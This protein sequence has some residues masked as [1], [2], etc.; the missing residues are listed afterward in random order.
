MAAPTPVPRRSTSD[1]RWPGWRSRRLRRTLIALAVLFVAFC[2]LTVRLFVFPVTGMPPRVDAVVVLGGQGSRLDLGLS[3]VGAGRS[4][5]LLLSEGLPWI[6]QGMCGERSGS[7]TILCFRPAPDTTQGEAESAARL[8]RQHNWRSL[9]LITTPDQVW[10][11]ELR[12]RRC[13]SG[14]IYAVTTPL[15]KSQWPFMIAYQWTASI[16]AELVN[17]GC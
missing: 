15:P 4:P 2:A 10:R 9:T 7:V 11:A 12:F 3:L 8:A 14:K 6:R 13:Y 17:R 16:K 5:V 1:R